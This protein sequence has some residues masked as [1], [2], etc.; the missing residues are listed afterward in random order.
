MRLLHDGSDTT[1]RVVK[2]RSSES[3]FS[4]REC[5]Y[6]GDRGPRSLHWVTSKLATPASIRAAMYLPHEVTL[7]SRIVRAVGDPCSGA[8]V[9]KCPLKKIVVIVVY[10]EYSVRMMY[11]V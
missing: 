4:P 1:W 10:G 9:G 11:V 5:P 3:S 6:R 2:R 8:T 7:T